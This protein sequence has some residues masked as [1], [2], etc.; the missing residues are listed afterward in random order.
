MK[1]NKIVIF[2]IVGLCCIL[3]SGCVTSLGEYAVIGLGSSLAETILSPSSSSKSDTKTD[4]IEEHII[5]SNLVQL[6]ITTYQNRPGYLFTAFDSNN[7]ELGKKFYR[8]A[9]ENDMK[10]YKPFKKMC[11]TDKKQ[12]IK[13]DFLALGIDLD[14]RSEIVTTVPTPITPTSTSSSI[15]TTSFAPIITPASY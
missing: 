2:S 12:F 7:Q 3:L 10:R 4:L 14:P 9:V 5:G 13:E 8:V 6:R 11:Q 15:P 1:S